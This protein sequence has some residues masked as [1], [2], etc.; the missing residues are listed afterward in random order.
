M[1]TE[2]EAK[3]KWC[4]MALMTHNNNTGFNRNADGRMVTYCIASNCMMW[5]WEYKNQCID[6]EATHIKVKS[7]KGY[8]GLTK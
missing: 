6:K 1:Y 2:D 7:N 5:K 4:P 3:K 8:C